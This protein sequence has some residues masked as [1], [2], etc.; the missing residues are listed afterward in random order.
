M[1]DHDAL[2]RAVL[3][4]PA[5]DAP[6]LVLA[7]WLEE[8]GHPDRAEFI[9]LQCARTA[10]DP[11][12]P[13]WE[14][15]ELELIE[16]RFVDFA[17]PLPTLLGPRAAWMTPFQE[18]PP[19]AYDRGF[20]AHAALACADLLRH[21]GRIFRA[22][23]LTAVRLRDREPFEGSPQSFSWYREG[24]PPPGGREF[25]PESNLPG[26]L[27]DALGGH[28]QETA[29]RGKWYET[30]ASAVEAASRAG[31]AYGRRLAGLSEFSGSVSPST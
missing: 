20:V 12:D 13:G 27:W 21:A 16:T 22:L 31:V 3:E 29:G 5:D 10:A 14:G 24:S 17:E 19:W 2:L 30:R 15:R 26:P 8:H 18:A 28:V 25:H 11:T 9:R 1:T 7:D 6:R 4:S 23:P